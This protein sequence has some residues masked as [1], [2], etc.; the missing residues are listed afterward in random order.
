MRRVDRSAAHVRARRGPELARTAPGRT[1][2]PEHDAILALQRA[3]GNTAVTELLGDPL[4]VV[5]RQVAQTGGGLTLPE[6]VGD[7]EL[8][9]AFR[10]DPP[11]RRQTPDEK[12]PAVF[13]VQKALK[14]VGFRMRAST[15]PTGE[16]DGIF[17]KETEATVLRFQVQHNLKDRDGRVG[18]DTLTKLQELLTPAGPK[19]FSLGKQAGVESFVVRW[20]EDPDIHEGSINL[21]YSATFQDD[22]QHDPRLAEFRQAIHLRV[23]VGGRVVVDD[24]RPDDGYGHRDGSFG[25]RNET[26]TATGYTGRD[27]PGFRPIQPDEDVLIEFTVTNTIIDLALGG[28]VIAQR[29]PH[30]ATIKGR[31]PRA[32]EGVPF[33]G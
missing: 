10:N 29:G 28:A 15:L 27:H 9:N 11:I 33:E 31:H 13:K 18:H 7:V 5:Q 23:V 17:G 2:R 20:S 26:Y 21:E 24:N 14:E 22:L 3:A 8:A 4:P 16:P 12:S 6:F 25:P 32:H 19:P 30:T 1:R